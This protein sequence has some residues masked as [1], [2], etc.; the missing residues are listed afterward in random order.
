LKVCKIED[1]I[2]KKALIKGEVG[3]GKTQYTE[4]LLLEAIKMGLIND[5][6]VIDMA[7]EMAFFGGRQIG[8]KMK[9]KSVF[10]SLRYLTDNEIAPPRIH[11]RT[12]EEVLEIANSNA[13]KIG[14]LIKCFLERKT[15]ILVINDLTIFLHAGDLRLIMNAISEAKTCVLNAYSGKMLLND[16]GSGISERE[17]ALLKKIEEEMDLVIIL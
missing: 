4:S 8:G 9:I 14:T 2:G 3:A 15:P 10:P 12:K 17:A 16:K 7:P 5:T 11:G 13:I 6:T 1:L